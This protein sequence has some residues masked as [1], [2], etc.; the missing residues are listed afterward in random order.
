MDGWF[1]PNDPRSN[2]RVVRHA[3]ARAASGEPWGD[4]DHFGQEQVM[5]IKATFAFALRYVEDIDAARRFYTEVLGM[6]PERVAPTFVQ[7]GAFALA[8]DE[9]VGAREET[10]LYWSID[11]AA[12]AHG[13]LSGAGREVTSIREMPFGKVF[14]VRD[15]A[16]LECFLIEFVAERPSE[17]V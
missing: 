10:E 13:E 1:A 17:R 14:T 15:A 3:R 5:A 2:A 11:D 4:E 12:A 9:R 8:S 6:T 7:F 16:G